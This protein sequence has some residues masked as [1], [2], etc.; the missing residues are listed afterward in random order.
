MGPLSTISKRAA[1][2]RGIDDRVSQKDRGALRGLSG[3][4]AAQQIRSAAAPN[5]IQFNGVGGLRTY[6]SHTHS[7][8][9]DGPERPATKPLCRA[10]EAVVK[11]R[12]LSD[13]PN[14]KPRV[15]QND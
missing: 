11:Q 6:I 7:E 14:S 4:R 15:R 5:K 10:D 12:R 8:L 3:P 1:S 13:I 9:P 2:W